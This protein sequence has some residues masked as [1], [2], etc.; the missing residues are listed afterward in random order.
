MTL[1]L[2]RMLSPTWWA[3]SV[4]EYTHLAIALC[5][6]FALWKALS[7]YRRR[8]QLLKALA[9]FPGPEPHWLLGNAHEFRL[10]GNDLEIQVKWAKQY[11]SA[12]PVWIGKFE[13]YVYITSCDYAKTLLGRADSKA[14]FYSFFLP[15]LGDGLLLQSGKK[16]SKRRKLL[17]P[18]LHYEI[19][20]P[21][22][23]LIS[24]CAKVMLGKWEKTSSENESMEIFEDVS[25]MTLDSIMKCTFGWQ[26]D[27][28]TE[29]DNKFVR[30]IYDLCF[31]VEHRFRF[32]P[33]HNDFMFLLSPHGIRFRRR[34]KLVHK[35]T[36]K[37]IKQRIES[38]KDVKELEIIQKKRHLDLLDI[39]LCSRDENGKGLSEEDLRAEVDTFMFEGHDT[40]ASAIS[41]TLYC[42]AKYPEHQE[43]CREEIKEILGDRRDI[44]WED[45]G[46][47]TYTTMCIKES[48]R[49]FPPV[50]G[51]GRQLG[52][53]ITFSDGRTLPAGNL[54]WVSIYAIHHDPNTWENPEV[55][56]PSRFA[57]D[58]PERHSHAFLPFVAGQRNC[59]GQTFAM[60]EVK[61]AIAQTLLR[62]ELS[63][64]LAKPP[65][66]IPQL[67]LR[68]KNGIHLH[69]KKIE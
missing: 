63:P 3:S 65:I 62:F 40:T 16:W 18:G 51:V 64:D 28:Q 4:A 48:F 38:L 32:F 42:M 34:C 6:A 58:A 15:W 13:A 20:K 19:L 52:K 60:N 56:D 36:D 50:P 5:V 47:M 2:G 49:I 25:L 53:P 57:A 66:K 69:V 68:S 21:Y 29:S 45:I 39:L 33:Y 8:L 7:F 1:G 55:F 14:W 44:E 43:K 46:K 9:Q 31:L 54:L 67:V 37:V 24:D 11:P 27:C 17:T 41:W 59:I 22:V 30:S 23:K 35:H 10:D 26:S 12:Y 61:V